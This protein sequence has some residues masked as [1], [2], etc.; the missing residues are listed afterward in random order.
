M[1]RLNGPG[2]TT[3]YFDFKAIAP[4]ELQAKDIHAVQVQVPPRAAA[5]PAP[6]LLTSQRSIRASLNTS[7][8]P[9]CFTALGIK[10]DLTNLLGL[11]PGPSGLNLT[12]P[13]AASQT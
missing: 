9:P 12:A 13:R 7:A 2:N 6:I 10:K 3:R 8:L 1:S 11:A 4:P 5:S